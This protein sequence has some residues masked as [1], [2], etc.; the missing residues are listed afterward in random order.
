M[1]IKIRNFEI[2]DLCEIARLTSQLGYPTSIQ[3]ILPR[4]QRLADNP[5]HR[6]LVAED[7]KLG[8]IAW[9]HLRVD[10]TLAS[11]PKIEVVGI[12]VDE[13][14][15]GEGIGR[16]LM[17]EAEKFARDMEYKMVRLRMNVARDDAH[18][19]YEALGY[20]LKKTSHMFVRELE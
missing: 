6:I 7:E 18:K 17:K 2:E 4:L 10:L 5:D 9:M 1:H 15:R 3:K 12:V 8:V 20:N 19:F 11:D 16:V 14:K 13:R